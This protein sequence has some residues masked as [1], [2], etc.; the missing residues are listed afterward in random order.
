MYSMLLQ[1]RCSLSVPLPA[2][3]FVPPSYACSHQWSVCHLYPY[4]ACSAHLILFDLI[5][6]IIFADKY[7]LWSPSLCGF[8]ELRY[9]FF[10]IG[11]NDI[12]TSISTTS[13]HFKIPCSQRGFALKY[14]H[15]F[16]CQ[17]IHHRFAEYQS[18]FS[19]S[20]T[21]LDF[22]IFYTLVSSWCVISQSEVGR[23]GTTTHNPR[24]FASDEQWHGPNHTLLCII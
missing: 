23:H 12:V 17:E 10:H 15:T 24:A 9:C 18:Y 2:S 19:I 7:R 6:Q 1:Y 8:L 13:S 22:S 16:R 5:T 20:D 11:Y 14:P 21:Q 4:S 3:M